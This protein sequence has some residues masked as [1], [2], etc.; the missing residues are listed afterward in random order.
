MTTLYKIDN[1]NKT[2]EW[3]IELSGDR[4]RTIYGEKDG[5][6]VTTEWT[7]CEGKNIG[8]ANETSPEVQAEKEVEAVIKKQREKGYMD[9]AIK[10]HGGPML[11]KSYDDYKDDIDYPI[12]SQPKLDGIRCVVDMLGMRTRNGKEIKSAPHIFEELKSIVEK[13]PAFTGFD[14]ELYNHDLKHNFNKICSL[15]KKLKPTTEDL[16]ESKKTVQYWIYDWTDNKMS[17]KDRTRHL[18]N[19]VKESAHIKLVPTE[20]IQNKEELDKYYEQYVNDGYEGQMI[21]VSDSMYE[22]KRTKNLLKRK[23]FLTEEFEIIGIEEGLGNRSGMAEL[24]EYLENCD[25]YIGKMG[26][27]KFF[28]YT[29]D[30]VP[31]FPYL[32]TV[33]DY[34]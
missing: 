14:G 17:F 32:L 24:E 27:V 33:R 19:L 5:Q 29:P 12:Y 25:D 15:V 3:T 34:E 20:V 8:R 16:D 30:K 21:R 22:E 31:R 9:K 10:V 18:S 6:L 11:A 1:K 13:Y 28:N 2:R 23:E 26:T 7:I 4:Y